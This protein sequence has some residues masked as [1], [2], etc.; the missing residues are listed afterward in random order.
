LVLTLARFGRWDEVLNEPL[1]PTDQL[2][3]K[4]MFHY[5]RGMSYAA[6]LNFAAAQ[7]ELSALEAIAGDPRTKPLDQPQLPGA[8]LIVLSQNILAGELAGRRLQNTEM[9]Q[10]FGAA[11]QLEDTEKIY[12]EDL[13]R[14]PA[15]GWSLYGLLSSLRVQG[16]TEEARAMEKR[17]RDVWRLADVTLTASRF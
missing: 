15:N 8:K 4:A 3:A 9:N 2:F 1:P 6:K 11:V 13:K 16:K 14:H 7:T 5:A 10:H 17:F 12:R